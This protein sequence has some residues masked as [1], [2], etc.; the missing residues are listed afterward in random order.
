MLYSFKLYSVCFCKFI[1][2][3]NYFILKAKR[4][5]ITKEDENISNKKDEKNKNNVD[6]CQGFFSQILYF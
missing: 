3:F 6:I 4:N 5:K 1:S 2:F